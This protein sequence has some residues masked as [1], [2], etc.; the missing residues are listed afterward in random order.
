MQ[1]YQVPYPDRNQNLILV[2]N[3]SNKVSTTYR[4]NSSN[5]S[6]N[7]DFHV[8]ITMNIEIKKTLKLLG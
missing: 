8:I 1:D 5:G 4:D 7:N 6:N 3:S 2:V